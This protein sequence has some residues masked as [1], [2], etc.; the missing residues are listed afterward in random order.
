MKRLIVE[1]LE[2]LCTLSH[3]VQHRRPFLWWGRTCWL[4]H[5]SDALDQ[6]WGTGRWREAD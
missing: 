1:G 3:P 5:W 4:S 6:R 2:R